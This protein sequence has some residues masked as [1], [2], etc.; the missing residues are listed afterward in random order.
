MLA[1]QINDLLPQT[2]A[3]GG[4]AINRCPPG[5]DDGI[6]KLARLLK[7]DAIPLDL[8]CGT[9]RR[10]Q[11]AV[12]DE[13]HCIGCTLCIQACP[14]DA[15]VGAAKRMHTVIADHCTGCDLCLPPCPVDCISMV[16]V[17]PERAW[18]SADASLAK[19]RYLARLNRA[20][21]TPDTLRFDPPDASPDAASNASPVG[22][23]ATQEDKQA[24]IA[25]MLARARAR[26]ADP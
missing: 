26:R 6:I 22:S 10:L 11:V 16:D 17:E 2:I 21:N 24:L 18:T 7:Q 23:P 15:I 4:A 9:H 25:Q 20:T 14:V 13:Q 3:S 19:G 8:T 1:D 12:I 5:G